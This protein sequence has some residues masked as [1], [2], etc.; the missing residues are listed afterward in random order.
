MPVGPAFWLRH[1]VRRPVVK[2]LSAILIG[3]S[4]LSVVVMVFSDLFVGILMQR[5]RSTTGLSRSRPAI[6]L[7]LTRFATRPQFTATDC[8]IYKLWLS[9][10]LHCV[11][12]QA[13]NYFH[14]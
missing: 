9:F 3:K 13:L 12:M 4:A 10:R 5:P 7:S 8:N 11:R 14:H 2:N 6:Y 1:H